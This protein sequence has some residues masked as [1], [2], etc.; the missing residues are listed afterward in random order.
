MRRAAEASV[1]LL[2]QEDNANITLEDLAASGLTTD[3]VFEEEDD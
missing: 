2:T 1:S 3:I